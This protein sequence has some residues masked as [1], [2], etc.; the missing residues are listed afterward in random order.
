MHP[1]EHLADMEYQSV[2]RFVSYYDSGCQHNQKA[3]EN[4]THGD[5][6]TKHGNAQNYCGDWFK[7]TKYGRG[8]GADK[9]YGPCGACE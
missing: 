9:L 8:S 6:L 5:A 4:I 1:G 2:N 3:T 7:S